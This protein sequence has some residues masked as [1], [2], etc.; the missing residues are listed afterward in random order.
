MVYQTTNL[1][2]AINKV[3]KGNKT[4]LS[5]EIREILIDDFVAFEVDVLRYTA[6]DLFE[7]LNKGVRTN[8]SR[9]SKCLKDDYKLEPYNGSYKKHFLTLNTSQKTIVDFETKKGRYYEFLKSDFLENSLIV[10]KTSNFW[11][12]Q[13]PLRVYKGSTVHQQQ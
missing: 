8:R 5:L 10:E 1:Y 2:P 13:K 4:Y 3:V 6:T 12:K 7:K 9:I 11:V